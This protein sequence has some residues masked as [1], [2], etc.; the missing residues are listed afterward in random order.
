MIKINKMK[1]ITAG[2]VDFLHRRS[3]I[4][5]RNKILNKIRRFSYGGLGPETFYLG[6]QLRNLDN[7]NK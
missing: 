6:K 5:E 3:Y 2:Y 7:K 4:K 1:K